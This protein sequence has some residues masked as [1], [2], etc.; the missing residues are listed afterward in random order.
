MRGT[1]KTLKAQKKETKERKKKEQAGVYFR[2]KISVWH[3]DDIGTG[4][5]WL[6]YCACG[7]LVLENCIENI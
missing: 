6:E 3:L 4:R 7:R 2:K 1:K 5:E